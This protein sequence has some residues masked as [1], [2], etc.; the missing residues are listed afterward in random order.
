MI[1]FQDGNTLA[2]DSVGDGRA[3]VYKGWKHAAYYDVYDEGSRTWIR[4]YTIV[5]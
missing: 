4:C 2:A 3:V 1:T 5:P